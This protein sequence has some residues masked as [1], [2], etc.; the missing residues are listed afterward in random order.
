MTVSTKMWVHEGDL[1]VLRTQDVE[2]FLE[3]N[4]RLKNEPQSR[5]SGFRHI[6][7]IP[8]IFLEQWLKEEADR[9]HVMKLW[10]KEMDELIAK[11]LRDPD[12]SFLRVDK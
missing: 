10:S 11:K 4:K 7:S 9:G 6:A 8:V 1:T 3:Y 12:Y 2:P 5:K